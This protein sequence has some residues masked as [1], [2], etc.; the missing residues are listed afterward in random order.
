MGKACQNNSY[1]LGMGFSELLVLQCSCAANAKLT[2]L[3]SHGS[4][5]STSLHCG[6]HKSQKTA[7][8][9]QQRSFGSVMELP[10]NVFTECTSA[11]VR[12]TTGQSRTAESCRSATCSWIL[13]KHMVVLS[14]V[15]TDYQQVLAENE[16]KHLNQRCFHVIY[17][18][19]FVAR[20]SMT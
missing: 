19:A 13:L 8:P 11:A 6:A 16:V 5:L 7:K 12:T 4:P 15:L 2:H 20:S 9:S 18:Q 10:H 14:H 1:S 3:D 17:P